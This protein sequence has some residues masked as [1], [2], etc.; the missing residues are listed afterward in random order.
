MR[1]MKLPLPCG[2]VAP[3]E[4]ASDDRDSFL[5]PTSKL[6][7]RAIRAHPYAPLPL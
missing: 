7:V 6:A 1:K 2:A 4:G 3:M 5:F